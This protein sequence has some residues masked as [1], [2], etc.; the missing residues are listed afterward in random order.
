MNEFKSVKAVQYAFN[1][2]RAGVLALIIKA[3]WK[4]YKQS[5]KGIFYYVIMALAFIA[6]AIFNV[7]VIYCIIACAVVGLVYSLALKGK[8]EK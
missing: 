5:P 3:L 7:Q 1:G 8:V 6:V 4:M 2:I